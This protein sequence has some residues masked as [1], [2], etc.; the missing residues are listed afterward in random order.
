MNST[1]AGRT[2]VELR[3]LFSSYGLPEQLVS[4]NSP[5]FVSDEFSTFMKMNGIKH[6]RCS[7]YHPSSNGA[8]E[9][10]VQTFKKAM[11][12]SQHSSLSFS[13]RLSNFLFTYR[14]T[15]HATTNEAPCQLFIGRM[16][17]TR[18][19]LLHPSDNQR[20]NN[21]QADQKAYHDRKVKERSL[22]I[23]QRVVVKSQIPGRPWVLG[24]LRKCKAL[25][26]I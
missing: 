2:I 7:P 11:K 17:R 19:D 24:S 20:V 18:F 1:T 9:R 15:Q 4:D 12:A 5:Q 25:L 26:H 14:C 23:G 21:K 22:M 3:R 10:F 8:A 6:I 16:L 13:H